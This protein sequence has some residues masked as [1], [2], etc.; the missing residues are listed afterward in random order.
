MARLL[1]AARPSRGRLDQRRLPQRAVRHRGPPGEAD[2]RARRERVH[3][4]VEPAP[5]ALAV[6]DPRSAV[7]PLARRGRHRVGAGHAQRPGPPPREGVALAALR[8]AGATAAPPRAAGAR[9]LRLQA[10]S[11]PTQQRPQRRSALQ[12]EPPLARRRLPQGGGGSAGAAVPQRP[13]PRPPPR[14]PLPPLRLRQQRLPGP[15]SP[16]WAPGRSRHAPQH[17]PVMRPDSLRG[18]QPALPRHHAR[19]L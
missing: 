7:A 3:D 10:P 5:A 14:P 9:E 6:G 8:A 17:A 13:P 19:G 1:A 11:A 18:L 12:L 4:P 2:R 15:W 16:T